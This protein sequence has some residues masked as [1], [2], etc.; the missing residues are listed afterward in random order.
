MKYSL[1]DFD[2]K[3][4]NGFV[5][6]E[7]VY[8]LWEEIRQSPDGIER[9]RLRKSQLEKK[10]VEELTPISRF[11]QAYYNQGRQ[12]K[13]KWKNGSQPND[14]EVFS[15]GWL[16]EQGYCPA[17]HYV[18][19]TTAVHKND[20]ILRQLLH[21]NGGGFTVKGIRRDSK[22]KKYLSEPYGYVNDEHVI[23]LAN[24]IIERIDAK[25]QK[26]YPDNTI[27]VIQCFTDT[28]I[29]ENEWEEA[30]RMVKNKKIKC[31]FKEV[32]VFESNHRFASTLFYFQEN[33]TPD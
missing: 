3:L 28:L 32:F 33:N 2:D 4:L 15:S 1:S 16:V 26:S 7:M 24:Q 23:D 11:I 20:H 14:L 31:R 18:E 13:V 19:V 29:F 21:E 12:L 10:L 27:L 30:I 6:C 8:S 25:N 5:F 22:T 17:N 9:I